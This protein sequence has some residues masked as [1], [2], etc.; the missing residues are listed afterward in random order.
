LGRALSGGVC[1]EDLSSSIPLDGKEIH[2]EVEAEG[3]GSYGSL[4][5]IVY[6]VDIA[7]KT[8]YVFYWQ[9]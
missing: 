2:L 6:N 7:N 1:F 4:I 3:G 9:K 5:E 8:E